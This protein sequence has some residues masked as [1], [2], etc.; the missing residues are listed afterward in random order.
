MKRRR[1]RRRHLVVL[2]AALSLAVG[3]GRDI[4]DAKPARIVSLNLCTDEL[5]LRLAEPD[6]IASVTWLARE[7][8]SSNV[9]DAALR[10]EINHGFAE[11]VAAAKPDVVV[12]GRYTARTTVALL[13]RT[14]IPVIDFDVPRSIDDVRNQ[15][16]IMARLLGEQDEAER[17]IERM[18]HRLA[19]VAP[20]PTP[21][22]RAIVLNPNGTTV[23]RGTLVDE[24]MTRAGMDN[25]AAQLGIDSYGIVPLETVVTSN[26]DIIIVGASRDGPPAMAMEILRHPVLGKAAARITVVDLPMRL[27]ACGGPT[28]VEA[29]ERLRNVVDIVGR[30]R[31]AP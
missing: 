12:A 14:G 15:I 30:K 23:G 28:V 27:L 6:R 7:P 29:V 4:V 22:P 10:V 8:G 25:V 13:K 21:R 20:P 3:L 19:A 26:L 11:E 5:V 18:N 17:L 2:A 31:T 9:A 16:R 24:I 1:S